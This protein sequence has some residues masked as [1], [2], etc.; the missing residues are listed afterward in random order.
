MNKLEQQIAFRVT[1]AQK[2]KVKRL[3]KKNKML[4][5]E[6]MRSLIDLDQ[7]IAEVLLI[8][9]KEQK[10]YVVDAGGDGYQT[11]VEYGALQ[12]VINKIKKI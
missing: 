7:P 4:E 12:R 3:A 8:I 6:Y 5:G 1:N 11:L 2:N 9:E 10:K